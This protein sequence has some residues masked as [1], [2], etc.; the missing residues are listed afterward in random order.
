MFS[1]FANKARR[2][3]PS[4][5]GHLSRTSPARATAALLLLVLASGPPA[6]SQP[7]E[8]A[9]I[10]VDGII[11]PAT[12]SYISRAIG[13]AEELNAP[14]LILRLDTPG[15]LL[16]ATQDIVS[17]LLGSPVPVVVYVSP[18]GAS[19]GSAGVFITLAAHVAAMAPATNIGAATPV[20]MGG[21]QPDPD[22]PVREKMISYA[23]SYIETI[24]AERER[25]VEWARSAVREGAS[26]TADE[27]VELNVI[28]LIAETETDLLTQLHGRVIG[29]DTLSTER[30]GVVEIGMTAVEQFFQILFRPELIFILMLV[31]MYGIIGELSNPGAI[32]PGL[33]GMIALLLLLYTI[34]VLPLNLVGFALIFLA[35]ALFVTELF[36]PSF[37][38]LSIA[39]AAA[40]IF[41]S[42]MIFED[43]SPAFDISLA[44][45]VPA[46]IVTALFFVF[47]IGAGL[48]AQLGKP[49]TGTESMVGQTAEAMS[50]IDAEGGKVFIEGEIWRAVSAQPVEKGGL[51][52]V[53]SVR[54]LTLD[55]TPEPNKE[56][57]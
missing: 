48:R 41:G 34:A 38:L 37:G 45:V 42:M 44:I 16:D 25:N 19:A 8:A 12:A 40:F 4:P 2:T 30:I 35:I 13:R 32:F 28:D 52:R 39:G 6:W 14:L 43:I 49:R 15:G 22:D 9:A 46:A 31:A 57:S 17:D 27:A 51:V 11:S 33:V 10:E 5:A 26:I 21:E 18:R 54:G 56:A 7:R 1:C 3:R 50:P 29:R 47:A 24:A 53:Q 23:E 55:V 20:Q 36:V